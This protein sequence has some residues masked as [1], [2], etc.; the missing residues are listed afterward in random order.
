MY[1]LE[2]SLI[3]YTYTLV[4]IDG[5]RIQYNQASTTSSSSDSDRINDDDDNDSA[6]SPTTTIQ[7]RQLSQ[8]I[9][10]C[11]RVIMATGSSRKGYQIV[12]KLGHEVSAPLPSLFSFKVKVYRY[13][14]RSLLF[15][16]KVF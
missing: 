3:Y 14:I 13:T 12:E 10:E 2:L 5:F 1:I 6:T 7:T 15:V 4:T 16:Y 11:D 9:Y 8:A